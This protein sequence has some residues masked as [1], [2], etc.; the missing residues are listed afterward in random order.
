MS[1]P[2]YPS[3]LVVRSLIPEGTHEATIVDIIPPKEVLTGSNYY[4]TFVLECKGE[5]CYVHYAGKLNTVYMIYR[6]KKLWLSLKVMLKV[7]IVETENRRFNSASIIWPEP[8]EAQ[9]ETG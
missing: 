9:S 6:N 5:R 8:D 4:V 2:N 1:E 7:D 3:K